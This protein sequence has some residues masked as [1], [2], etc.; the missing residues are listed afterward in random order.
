VTAGAAVESTYLEAIAAALRDEMRR[1]DRVFLIGE[2]IATMGG[3]FKLTKGFLEEFGAD[4]VVD[5]PI[6]ES[7]IIGACIGAALLGRRPV[8][9][10]Q[11]AD[12]VACGFNQIVSNAATWHY[13]TGTP[14]PFVVRLPF[15]G[16]ISGGPFHSRC[17]EAWF[18]HQ[19]GLKVVAPSTPEDAHGLL[20]ASM[21]DDNPVMYLE[22]KY[23]YRRRKAVLPEGDH[24]VPLGKGVVRRQGRDA[25]VLTYGWMVHEA[26]AAADTIASGGGKQVEVVDLR[27]LLPFDREL[28]LERAA[29]CHRVLVLHEAPLLGG[30]GGELAAFIGEHAFE[31][32]DAPVTRLG[33]LD[34]PVPFAAPLE[35]A[36]LPTRE[37]IQAA[38]DAL[39]A[40]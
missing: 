9:E 30:V 10:M 36:Y 35:Q 4:R 39:L 14:L 22:H 32:L 5:T 25:V 20:V 31:S 23:L 37:K 13:R 33:A 19:P 1:D 27:T 12:F 21:R 7:A 16:G 28:L 40:Y 3:A 38:L 34:T 6:A 8:A 15:G 24:V 2:D 18:V 11:F 26:V 17:P 29:A